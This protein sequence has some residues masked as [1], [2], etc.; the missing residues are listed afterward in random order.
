MVT[1]FSSFEEMVAKKV[2]EIME[3]FCEEEAQEWCD[4]KRIIEIKV[5]DRILKIVHTKHN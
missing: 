1:Q 2:K 4:G 5:V 3:S